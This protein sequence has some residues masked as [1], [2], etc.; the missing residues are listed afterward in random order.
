MMLR[1][2]TCFNRDEKGRVRRNRLK[3]LHQQVQTTKTDEKAIVIKMP[4]GNE[5]KLYK[6]TLAQFLSHMFEGYSHLNQQ[7]ST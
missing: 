7:K 2:L 4:T 6:S 1:V 5:I 3:Q